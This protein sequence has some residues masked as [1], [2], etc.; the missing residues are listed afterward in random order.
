M[1]T[2]GHLAMRLALGLFF[3]HDYYSAIKALLSSL[4]C[5]SIGAIQPGIAYYDYSRASSDRLSAHSNN[6]K[7]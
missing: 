1:I 6:Y 7:I 2:A 4:F 3:P 5:I